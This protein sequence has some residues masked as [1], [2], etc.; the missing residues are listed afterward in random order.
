[1]KPISIEEAKRISENAL[2]FTS[3]ANYCRDLVYTC[4][5]HPR[6]D[7]ELWDMVVLTYTAYMAG[8]VTAA[9]RGR[10]QNV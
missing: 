1:M 6:D 7:W 10:G 9:R 8:A 3:L 2:N 5:L 4:G